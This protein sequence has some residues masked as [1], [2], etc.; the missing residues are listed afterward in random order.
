VRN[1]FGEVVRLGD[2]VKY[3]T[4][5][6]LFTIMRY[7]RQ[8]SI[9]VYANPAKGASQEE[10]LK[11][12]HEIAKGIL[13]DGYN[14]LESGNAQ[15]FKESFESLIFVLIL[16]IFVAYMVLATQFNSFIHPVTILLALPFSVTGAFVALWL[17]GRS[18]NIY[19][20]IGL[21]LLMGI[22]KK[23]SILLVDFTNERRK[24]GAKL[25]EALLEACPIR[26]RPILMTSVATI[27]G[28]T[29][30]ALSRGAGSEL[31]V[32]MAV[33]VIGGVFLSTLLTLFVV[34]CFYEL[35]S[36]F[37]SHRHDAELKEALQEL[38]E[39]PA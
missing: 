21:I 31:M 2:V 23:N 30:I 28:A 37:E 22:V 3:E 18:L 20:M 39:L 6:A 9:T 36:R 19:S 33:T 14:I 4:Q 16:G 29:P 13:P 34:P 15:L 11:K 35:V 24:R 12:V 1:N 8:R 7:N 32:P 17:T 25:R 27:A 38:G 5:P 10:A 26:L